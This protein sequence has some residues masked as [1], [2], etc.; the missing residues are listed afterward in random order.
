MRGVVEW[1]RRSRGG[2]GGSRGWDKQQYP[3]FLLFP[4]K[5]MSCRQH[6]GAGIVTGRF[7][8]L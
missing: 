2:G 6:H 5:S 7:V 1:G 8:G 3:M 4:G